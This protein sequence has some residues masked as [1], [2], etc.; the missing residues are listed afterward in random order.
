M[1]GVRDGIP[2]ALPP[3][4]PDTIPIPVDAAY[5]PPAFGSEAT[6][7]SHVQEAHDTPKWQ[8]YNHGYTDPDALLYMTDKFENETEETGKDLLKRWLA[9]KGD[10]LGNNMMEYAKR[11]RELTRKRAEEAAGPEKPLRPPPYVYGGDIAKFKRHRAAKKELSS[12]YPDQWVLSGALDELEHM[13][14]AD[15][16]AA[17]TRWVSDG[18]DEQRAQ[19]WADRARAKAIATRQRSDR[20]AMSNTLAMRQ[21]YDPL[22]VEPRLATLH[23]DPLSRGGML[24]FILNLD[25]EEAIQTVARWESD[26]Q[27]VGGRIKQYAPHGSRV[28]NWQRLLPG[29]KGPTPVDAEND[30]FDRRLVRNGNYNLA[31]MRLAMLRSLR[32]SSPATKAAKI[33][34]WE[35]DAKDNYDA[36]ANRISTWTRLGDALLALYVDSHPS[37]RSGE[38]L[39]HSAM[40]AFENEAG[41]KKLSWVEQERISELCRRTRSPE[42]QRSIRILMKDSG[43][44]TDFP[45]LA[46]ASDIL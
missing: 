40:L 31:R 2:M 27:G 35:D 21:V 16:E 45:V 33:K 7:P 42:E 25:K 34:R 30:G 10:T 39:D 23:H 26:P 20:T 46:A 38:P 15:N 28:L 22:R 11:G 6:D 8:L 29:Y 43:I 24:H 3:P 37:E 5:P 12:I 1:Q 13:S 36:T 17:L 14:D 41:W 18:A 44:A 9:T 4:L 32:R 19:R